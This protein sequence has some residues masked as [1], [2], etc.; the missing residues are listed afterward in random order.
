MKNS[1]L[2]KQTFKVIENPNIKNFLNFI[3][4]V[5]VD[6][7]KKSEKIQKPEKKHVVTKVTKSDLHNSDVARDYRKKMQDP[8]FDKSDCEFFKNNEKIVFGNSEKI[9]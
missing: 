1:K 4:T 7:S 8:N 9:K 5:L 6:E 3:E 2:V